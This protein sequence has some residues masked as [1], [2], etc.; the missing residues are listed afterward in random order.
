MVGS[1]KGFTLIELIF[2]IVVIAVT[3]MSLPMVSEVTTNSSASNLEVKELVFETYVQA[4]QTAED[5]FANVSSSGSSTV[6]ERTTT[7]KILGLKQDNTVTITVTSNAEF[8][9][10]ENNATIKAKT[11]K[12]A[13]SVTSAR[14]NTI[15]AKFYVFD[16]DINTTR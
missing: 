1:R 7:D 6:V 5:E 11:K 14:D 15:Y 10:N 4:L 2:A 8:D 13:V 16:F 9:P 3:V 12:I